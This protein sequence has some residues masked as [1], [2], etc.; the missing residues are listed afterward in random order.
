MLPVK[1]AEPTK[2]NRHQFFQAG[3][4]IVALSGM[5]ACAAWQ[6]FKAHRLKNDPNCIRLYTCN[7]CV[8]FGSGCQL[9]KAENFCSQQTERS[10]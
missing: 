6:T 1:E 4:R 2:E 5:V 3:A 7:H 9:P 10:G 8:E